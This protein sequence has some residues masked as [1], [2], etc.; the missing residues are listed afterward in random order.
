MESRIFSIKL[1]TEELKN[2]R[3]TLAGT[4]VNYLQACILDSC[5]YNKNLHQSHNNSFQLLAGFSNSGPNKHLPLLN[6]RWKF[7]HLSYELKDQLQ[8]NLTSHHKQWSGFDACNFFEPEILVTVKDDSLKVELTD[9][10]LSAEAWYNSITSISDKQNRSVQSE[11]CYMSLPKY[12]MAFNKIMHHILNGDIYEMNYCIPFSIKDDA[13]DPVNAWLH[14]TDENPSPFSALYKCNDSWLISTSPERFIRKENQHIFSQP[15]KG[16]APRSND[17]QSD[18][19]NAHTLLNSEKERSENI[20]ITDLVRNDLSRIAERSSVKVDE[21]CGLYRFPKVYQLISTISAT[22]KKDISF[23]QILEA[24]F[25]AGSMTG[26]PKHSAMKI[27]EETETF[28][29]EIYSGAVGYITPDNDFDFNVVIRSI[30]YNAA[31]GTV[32]F[33]AGSAVTAQSDCDAEYRECLLK[34]RAMAA[35]AGLTLNVAGET[36]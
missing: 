9:R 14:L 20:M 2:L 15:I 19:H 6:D 16:T 25:P 7:G 36:V 33:P 8:A 22:L 24:L 23:K 34:A 18:Q 5:D 26:A 1:N 10:S 11:V 28:R 12:K 27:I 21:L 3:I 4:S 13:F 29:R 35:A 32:M 31:S 17:E 30:I